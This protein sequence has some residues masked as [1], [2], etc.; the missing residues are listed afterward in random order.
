MRQLCSWLHAVVLSAQHTCMSDLCAAAWQKQ[1]LSTID[2][3]CVLWCVL[4][5]SYGGVQLHSRQ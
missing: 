4:Q 5:E 3:H 1:R 2:F